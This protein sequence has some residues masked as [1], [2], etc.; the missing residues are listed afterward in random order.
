MPS[1]SQAFKEIYEHRHRNG[2]IATAHEPGIDLFDIAAIIILGQWHQTPGGVI[3]DNAEPDAKMVS[4]AGVRILRHRLLWEW[5]FRKN[6]RTNNPI[7]MPMAR[8]SPHGLLEQRMPQLATIRSFLAVFVLLVN[9]A[10]CSPAPVSPPTA[11]NNQAMS[12]LDR[13]SQLAISVQRLRNLPP[14][15]LAAGDQIAFGTLMFDPVASGSAI[16]RLGDV[17]EL[18][19]HHVLCGSSLDQDNLAWLMG[20]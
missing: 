1:I 12:S 7:T 2:R 9:V 20:D 15:P 16:T 3:A 13:A 18:G 17:W 19:D 5:P 6:K 4:A 11:E 14:A 10:N 8:L